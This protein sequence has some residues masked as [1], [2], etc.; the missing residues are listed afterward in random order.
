M[1][2]GKDPL[3]QEIFTKMRS[4]QKFANPRNRIRYNNLKARNKRYAK[5][6]VDSK[7]DRNRTIM[8]NILG[9]QK[10]VTVSKDY[11]LG[12]G[13]SFEYFSYQTK[14][15]DIVYFG[16][17]EFGIARLGNNNFKLIKVVN[18]QNV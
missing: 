1:E 10:E 2:Q 3:T 14:I 15:N 12:S 13:F 16:I 11:L 7:L 8:G 5:S 17:Y 9:T 18:G 6:H 4:N